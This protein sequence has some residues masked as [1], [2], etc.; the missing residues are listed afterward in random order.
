MSFYFH[1]QLPSSGASMNPVRTL[2]PAFVMNRWKYHWVYWIAPITGGMLAALIYHFIFD[3]KK[4]NSNRNAYEFEKE[5]HQE[6]DSECDVK[7]NNKKSSSS[8]ITGVNN[9]GITYSTS[10][11]SSNSSA[12]LRSNHSSFTAMQGSNIYDNYTTAGASM[13]GEQL[14]SAHY[15]QTLTLPSNNYYYSTATYDGIYNTRNPHL[16]KSLP[17]MDFISTKGIT[18]NGQTKF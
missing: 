13:A 11:T 10:A 1:R 9:A 17:K 6:S 12:A 18:A 15:Q 14:G 5:S 4:M 16:L 3:T 2:G 7:A 8:V